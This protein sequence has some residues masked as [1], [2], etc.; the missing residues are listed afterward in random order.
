MNA[1]Q[2]PRLLSGAL[3]SLVIVATTLAPAAAVAQEP[4]EPIMPPP[5][6]FVPPN[7]PVDPTGGLSEA[8]LEAAEALS[9]AG[10]ADAASVDFG[11]ATTRIY[12]PLLE[13]EHNARAA[14]RLGFGLN[15]AG[16][17]LLFPDIRTLNAGWYNNWSTRITPVRPYGMEFVQ[18]VR[19]HQKIDER[20]EYAPGV[21]CAIGMTADRTICPYRG[22]EYEFQPEPD[23]I[24]RAAIKN[25]GS[26]WV[27][28]NEMERSDWNGGRMDE[29]LPEV[30]ARAYHYLRG[31][32]KEA[33]P[34]ARIAIGGVIQFT[35]LR[36]Q[37]LDRVW[38][39]YRRLYGHDMPV[40]VWNVHN[41][42]G[43]EYCIA[44]DP[45]TPR[46][47]YVCKGM[48]RPV[49]TTVT[50]S[51]RPSYEGRDNLHIDRATF[52]RQIRDFRAWMKA[53]GQMNK[54]LIVTEYGVLYTTLCNQ[55]NST[56]RRECREWYEDRGGYVDLED[57]Q[58]IHEFMIWT[59][60]FFTTEADC[61][62]SG[63]DDCLLVQKWAW[64]S[65]QQHDGDVNPHGPL[66]TSIYEG[67]PQMTEAGRLFRSFAVNRWADLQDN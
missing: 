33:D 16:T 43:A 38:N 35:P 59:F 46:V 20:F 2:I 54:D 32:I 15:Y 36:R 60:D 23:V 5:A 64:F 26:I 66:Y 27:I 25:P 6:S 57:P 42:I 24:R 30:Y 48:G 13:N 40:D 8:E 11:D 31:K 22:S 44:D 39:E 51:D 1:V 58:L 28:G 21:P 49:G 61:N 55:E 50:G 47:E 9:A 67:T 17:P 10:A 56:E 19:V 52:E 29:M 3:L 4:A 63:A 65:L 37:Y 45:E 41:F 53:K 18:T 14:D 62:L 7:R 12:L 34:T